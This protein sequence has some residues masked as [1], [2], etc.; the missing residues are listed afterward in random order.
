ML[1]PARLWEKLCE[2]FLCYAAHLPFFI[3]KN[4]SVT[5]CSCIKCHYI[6]C[7]LQIPPS[8]HI[9]SRERTFV[10]QNK[11]HNKRQH[12]CCI[13]RALVSWLVLFIYVH[14]I[15]YCQYLYKQ[16]LYFVVKMCSFNV[17]LRGILCI[18]TTL[19]LPYIFICCRNRY[20]PCL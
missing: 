19:H 1:N 16:F 12:F 8:L 5:C 15:T 14:N 9:P 10:L 13:C 18:F 6:F 4:T 3:E 11:K 7:H 17:F 2:F 20:S